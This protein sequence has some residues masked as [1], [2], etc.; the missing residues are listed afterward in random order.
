MFIFKT[1]NYTHLYGVGTKLLNNNNNLK[2]NVTT[3][4]SRFPNL[5]YVHVYKCI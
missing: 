3:H 2:M 4:D 1:T 5:K